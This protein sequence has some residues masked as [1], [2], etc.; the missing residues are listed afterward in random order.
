MNADENP[1][2]PPWALLLLLGKMEDVAKG[3]M[4]RTVRLL[5]PMA[6][7]MFGEDDLLR[8]NLEK[9]DMMIMMVHNLN[10]GCF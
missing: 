9:D 3:E 7:M 6:P 2:D 8:I 5:P 1:R 10:R 4:E